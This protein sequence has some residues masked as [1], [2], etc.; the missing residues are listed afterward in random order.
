MS[1]NEAIGDDYGFHC[2]T[3]AVYFN[4]MHSHKIMTICM[5]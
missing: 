5:Y 4:K 1:S 3:K 2:P